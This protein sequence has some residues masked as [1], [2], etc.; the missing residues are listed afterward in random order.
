MQEGSS[1]SS[2]SATLGVVGLFTL[3]PSN[4]CVGKSTVFE[5]AFPK[6][7]MMVDIF[8]S[9]KL[10]V[11]VA[12][13]SEH[14]I[15]SMDLGSTKYCILET[16]L[17]LKS[18]PSWVGSGLLCKCDGGEA[19][20]GNHQRQSSLE[21]FKSEIHQIW[22]WTN[23]SLALL[24]QSLSFQWKLL[25]EPQFYPKDHPWLKMNKMRNRE[26]IRFH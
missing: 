7:L 24:K 6:R 18:L 10:G 1:C 11:M 8:L 4:G 23:S 19:S 25:K 22:H 3:S 14:W 20:A 21:S 9:E 13:L 2:F 5:F 12:L 17:R 16:K 26:E 15:S